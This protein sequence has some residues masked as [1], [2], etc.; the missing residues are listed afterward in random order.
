MSKP[1]AAN[2]ALGSQAKT[3]SVAK[4]TTAV[5][6][7]TKKLS[8]SGLGRAS[9]IVAT[10]DDTRLGRRV[11]VAMNV[12]AKVE[13]N[14]AEEPSNVFMDP[15]IGRWVLLRTPTKAA[16]VSPAVSA[17]IPASAG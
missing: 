5:R 14:I 6:K 2:S 1:K 3:Q 8:S 15:G 7:G 10:T 11:F 4:N 17:M 9:T 13:R 16:T 12:S